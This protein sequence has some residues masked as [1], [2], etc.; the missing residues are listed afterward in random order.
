MA[1]Y[2]PQIHR[3]ESLAE[4]S[5]AL[6]DFIVDSCLAEI[7]LK[8]YFTFVLS[9]GS[10]PKL[11]YEM[12][13]KSPYFEQ[14]LWHKLY[15]F[16]GDE[17]CVSPEDE[18][19]NY[20]MVDSLLLSGVDIPLENIFRMPGEHDDPQSGAELYEQA[21]AAFF[22]SKGINI[23]PG[24]GFPEFDFLLQGLGAD[25]H[26]ASLFPSDPSLDET[27]RWVTSVARSP[28]K[29]NMPRITL[30]LP[31]INHGKRIVFL[32]AG[33]QKQKLLQEFQANFDQANKKYPAAMV[34]PNGEL[35]WYVTKE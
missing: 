12:L 30:T 34:Q 24:Q 21:I 3:F 35:R 22:A 8:G 10:T 29:P 11:L 13:G 31:T 28:T 32:I 7:D 9:G 1:V 20:R 25:G 16:W 6:A 18:H 23:T 19:S 33:E 14:I 27:T 5:R 2:N 17:R 4:A 15:L 26:T